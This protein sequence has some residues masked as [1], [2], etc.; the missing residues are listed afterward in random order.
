[1]SRNIE[2]AIGTPDSSGL[3][4]RRRLKSKIVEAVGL[5]GRLEGAHRVVA[6]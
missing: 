2:A 6:V 4:R 5:L 1:M 3:A